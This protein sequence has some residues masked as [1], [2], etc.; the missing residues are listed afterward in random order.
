MKEKFNIELV[1]IS[2]T[3][4]IYNILSP[5]RLWEFFRSDRMYVGFVRIPSFYDI[6]YAPQTLRDFVFDEYNRSDIPDKY[7]KQIL[8]YLTNNVPAKAD[9]K[10]Q[11]EKFIKQMDKLDSI[12]STNWKETFP[13]ISKRIIDV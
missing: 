7:R 3:V 5:I 1:F 10:I 9:Q 12:R 6:A 11:V 4:G 8:G 2:T 13:E